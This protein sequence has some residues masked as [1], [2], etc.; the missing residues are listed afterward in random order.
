MKNYKQT[1]E[2]ANI[3]QN[4]LYILSWCNNKHFLEGQVRDKDKIHMHHPLK[5]LVKIGLVKIKGHFY[6]VKS[7]EI[8]SCNQEGYVQSLRFTTSGKKLVGILNI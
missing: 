2:E 3:N 6:T 4:I 7:V 1:L 8:N 5:T